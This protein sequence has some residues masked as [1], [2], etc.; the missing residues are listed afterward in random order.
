MIHCYTPNNQ[1][2]VKQF[3]EDTVL[4]YLTASFLFLL[5]MKGIVHP[6]MYVVPHPSF[7]LQLNIL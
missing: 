1:Y 3:I 4:L 2:V 5:K 6:K 7:F